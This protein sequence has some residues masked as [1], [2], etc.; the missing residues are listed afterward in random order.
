MAEDLLQSVYL[1]VLEQEARLTGRYVSFKSCV[2]DEM[3]I[4]FTHR[5]YAIGGKIKVRP[6]HR[7]TCHNGLIIANVGMLSHN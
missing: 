2:G 6:T 4:V 3:F 7:N 1:K 5:F